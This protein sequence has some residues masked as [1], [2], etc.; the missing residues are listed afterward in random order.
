VARIVSGQRDERAI[1]VAEL[2]DSC[3]AG[4]GDQ[5]GRSDVVRPNCPARKLPIARQLSDGQTG[6]R[7]I[8]GERDAEHTTI[9]RR[10]IF[11]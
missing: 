9:D 2:S 5:A 3:G 1:G 8:S 10:I 6:K 4:P 7:T 11:A